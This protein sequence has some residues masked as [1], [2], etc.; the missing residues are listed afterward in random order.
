[1]ELSK[2]GRA[3]SFRR[4]SI[5][6]SGRRFMRLCSASG[7]RRIARPLLFRRFNRD[8]RRHP[9]IDSPP[10]GWTSEVGAGVQGSC[11]GTVIQIGLPTE[12]RGSP[13]LRDGTL[14]TWRVI[15]V[16][17]PGEAAASYD[18]TS[19][20]GS[21]GTVAAR[22]FGLMDIQAGA[23]RSWFERFDWLYAM[24]RRGW[25]SRGSVGGVGSAA[26]EGGAVSSCV[27]VLSLSLCT[28]VSAS[29][30]AIRGITIRH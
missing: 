16:S 21:L 5:W 19:P 7:S 17:V 30:A 14:G 1:M 11:L 4:R 13:L 18:R 9:A 6:L 25:M 29:A 3:R 27:R 24:Q 8:R 28:P 2:V 22:W 26:G 20:R 10:R 12:L 23:T 15:L